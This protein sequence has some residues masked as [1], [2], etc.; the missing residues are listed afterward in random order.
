LGYYAIKYHHPYIIQG[1]LFM[2]NQDIVEDKGSSE[3]VELKKEGFDDYN[4]PTEVDYDIQLGR[5]G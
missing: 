3:V 1:V 5:A 4:D 2:P